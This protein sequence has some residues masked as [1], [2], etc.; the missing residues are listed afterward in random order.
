[1]E[2]ATGTVARNSGASP[3]GSRRNADF[4]AIG[5]RREIRKGLLSWVEVFAN[6]SSPIDVAICKQSSSSTAS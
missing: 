4:R 6:V 3:I 2:T 5:S 1:M